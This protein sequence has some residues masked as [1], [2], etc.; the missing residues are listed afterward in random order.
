MPQN[1]ADF[2][3]SSYFTISNS[4]SHKSQYEICLLTALSSLYY[5]DRHE[6]FNFAIQY[7]ET[8]KALGYG[9]GELKK[10]HAAYKLRRGAK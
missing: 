4:K 6:P 10:I 2:N 1:L 8:S 7:S 9:I 3:P 5:L